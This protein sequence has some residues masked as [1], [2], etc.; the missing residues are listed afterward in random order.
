[1]GS[2]SWP[3]Y[4]TGPLPTIRQLNSVGAQQSV[5]TPCATGL[6]SE[7]SI[8]ASIY[9]PGFSLI[10]TV[11]LI[12]STGMSPS[13]TSPRQRRHHC[14]YC[15]AEVMLRRRFCVSICSVFFRASRR[16]QVLLLCQV[17]VLCQCQCCVLKE[18]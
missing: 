6:L 4:A 8:S 13:L 16:C 5:H 1:M 7:S 12:F 14:R 9:Q 15:H 10:L 11:G 3:D 2:A 18:S 17:P